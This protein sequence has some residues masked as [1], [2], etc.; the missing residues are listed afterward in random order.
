MTFK[1]SLTFHNSLARSLSPACVVLATLITASCAT[2]QTDLTRSTGQSTSQ[3]TELS[4]EQQDNQWQN[5]AAGSAPLITS[6]G[7]LSSS[8]QRKIALRQLAERSIRTDHPGEYTVVKG[9]T[10]WDI[11]GRFLSRPWLWPEIWHVNPQ[12]ENPHLIYPGDRIALSYVDGSPRLQVIR[13]NSRPS[14][15]GSSRQA[16]PIGTIP[17]DAIEQ[18]INEP[19]VV[20]E[21]DVKTS[22]YVA[23]ADSGRLASST[24][25][26]IYVR[27]D[28]NGQSRY[29]VFRPGDA[30]IDPETRE[31]LG[32]E[33]ILVS[34]VSLIKSGDPSKMLIT[35]NTRET[36]VGDRLMISNSPT[37]AFFQPRAADANTNGRIISLVDAVSRSG[38]NQVVVLNVGSDDGVQPGD[39]F[40]VIGNDRTVRDDV[41]QN[42]EYFTV[43]GEQAGVVMVFRSFDRVSYALIMSSTRSIKLY[44]RVGST[45]NQL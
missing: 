15:Q 17:L 43:P 24:G 10:L 39:T 18:F 31:L 23:A 21:A 22:A 35:S 19:L 1:T 20:T 45:A 2:S 3:S 8:Q 42:G 16:T 37:P 26:H 41:G 44:D 5:V 30:L 29:S 13:A 32:R 40:S 4:S 6:P 33:A 27:G 12:I 11:S 34:K 7:T 25:D 36:L 38:Q 9:D 14:G 28:L